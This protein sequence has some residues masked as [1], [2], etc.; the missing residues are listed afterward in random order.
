MLTQLTLDCIAWK[1]DEFLALIKCRPHAYVEQLYLA[2]MASVTAK[3]PQ[4]DDSKICGKITKISEL[5]DPINK[6]EARILNIAGVGLELA[7]V[8]EYWDC[9]EEVQQWL[10]DILCGIMEGVDVLVQSHTSC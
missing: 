2:F 10:E 5:I 4:G 6:H 7:E 9:M 1:N 8:H 3:Q